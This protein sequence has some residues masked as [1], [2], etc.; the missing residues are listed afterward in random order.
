MKVNPQRPHKNTPSKNNE[1]TKVS[2][3]QEKRIRRPPNSFL[4]YR[5]AI[6]PEITRYYEYII[7]MDPTIFPWY[8]GQFENNNPTK[9]PLILPKDDSY[10]VINTYN[11]NNNAQ[12]SLIETTTSITYPYYDNTYPY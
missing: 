4:L 5:Q 12:Q 7:A 11:D 8:Y 10:N 9:L 2:S 1:P 6:Q 3:N